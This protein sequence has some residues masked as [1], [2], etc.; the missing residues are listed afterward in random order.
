MARV[1][2]ESVGC[3]VSLADAEGLQA[4]LLAAGHEAAACADEADVAVVTT[5]CV[6]AE[7]ERSSRQR[8]R[9]LATKGLPVVVAGC[10][11][12]YRPEQ[13][14]VDGVVISSREGVPAA[15]S[16]VLARTATHGAG[17]GAHARQD[18]TVGSLA[19]AARSDGS[20][21]CHRRGR[22]RAVLKVQDGCASACTYCAV[23]LVRGEPWS[24]PLT[25]A[26]DAARAVLRSGCGELVISGINLGLYSGSRESGA[27]AD[28]A[29]LV[30]AL[31]EL[32]GLQRL[33]LSSIEPL[34]VD[35]RLL[36]VL[37]H[38][39]VARHLHV[40]LQSADDGVLTDMGRPYTF[41]RYCDTLAAVR[42]ALPGAM[43]STDV[44]VGFPTESETAFERTL[45]AIGGPD[46]LF[47]RVHVFTYSPRPG[48]AAARLR[49]LPA[50]ELRRRR[51]AA[52][53]AAAAAQEAA[54]ERL[55]GGTV[56]VLLED[57]RN[58]YWRGYSSEYAR[59]V[60]AGPGRRGT[61]VTARV[62]DRVSAELLCEVV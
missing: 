34:H 11:V 28:L 27:P 52:L 29:E 54:A 62:R 43:I 30:A 3:K 21:A 25:D 17:F 12:G 2:A 16:A 39:R 36:R 6:T 7:A 53:A 60:V 56:E 5:C 48:T 45:A 37:A 40:P 42:A 51:A 35:A 15:V 22:T 55:V 14:A 33:R 10:A 19:D 49:P 31:V 57:R 58:G 4:G 23:R 44:I 50:A 61:L 18:A 32:S 1:W 13:F 26:V 8:V 9:R 47:G 46:G 24:L 38:A 20:T 41:A 59:C